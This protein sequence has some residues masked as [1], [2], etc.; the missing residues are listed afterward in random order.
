MT[1][2]VHIQVN[3]MKRDLDHVKEVLE[4]SKKIQDQT[5]EVLTELA[6]RNRENTGAINFLAMLV[7][8]HN[9]ENRPE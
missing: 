1:T 6:Y 7:A 9:R 8:D 2:P 4:E 5:N 3:Q